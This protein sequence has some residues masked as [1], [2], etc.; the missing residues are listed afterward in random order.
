MSKIS[1]IT[2]FIFIVSITY[3]QK[4]K[5][6]SAL[7]DKEA[8]KLDQALLSIEEAVNPANPKSESSIAWAHTWEVRGDIYEA[9]YKSKE[10]KFKKLHADPLLEALNSYQKATELDEKGKLANAL[11]I[12]MQVLINDLSEQAVNAFNE[13]DYNKALA[14]FEQILTIEDNPLYKEASS[15]AVDTAIIFNAGLAA[16]K[17]EQ[18]DK[19]IELNKKAARYQYSG[20][21]TYEL[22]ALS[23]MAKKD[24]AGALTVIQDGLQQYP[25]NSFLLNQVIDIYIGK[26][27]IDDAMKYLDLAISKKADNEIM[28]LVRGNLLVKLNR[29]DEAVKCYEKAITLK[30]D[31][32]DAYFNLGNVYYTQGVKQTELANE[33]P[34]NN[35]VKYDE[36]K[37]KADEEFKKALPYLEKAYS[38]NDSDRLTLESLKNVYYRLQMLDKH[39]AIVEKIKS[40]Q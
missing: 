33:V 26:N 37:A 25:D 31:F 29:Y 16:Y 23:Y 14:S 18:Y 19:A 24:S 15:N 4:T 9:I 36:E 2:I 6:N 20:S 8:G 10:D 32:M 38:I 34:S 28:H 11:K 7:M 17:A 22:M 40:N 21:R 1:L 27:K 39:A 30:P 3:G 12:K 5:V 13:P 35:V